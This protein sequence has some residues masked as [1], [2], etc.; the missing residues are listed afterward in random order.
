MTERSASGLPNVSGT[1]DNRPEMAA[2]LIVPAALLVVILLVF[3]LVL[4]FR[5]SL[6]IFSP[7]ELMIE[8]F[9]WQNY[10]SAVSD[11]YYL[12]TMA[13]TLRVSVLCTLFSLTVGFPAAYAL[14]RM[15]RPWKSWLT[16]LTI[17][18]LMVGGVV[19]SAG[20][21]MLLGNAGLVNAGLRWVNLTDAPLQMIYTPAAVILALVSVVLPYMILTLASVIEAIPRQLEEAALNMGARPFTV[22]RRV[23]FPLALPG[24]IAASALVFIL[25]MN[26]YATPVL[27]GGAKFK[28][29]APAVYDQFVRTTNWPF[30][31]ALALIMLMVTL[32]LTLV[33]S[34][35]LQRRYYTR[36]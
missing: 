24:V 34:A 27:V 20:W 33:G 28:M 16:L 2:L 8:A 32:T 21:L 4:L 29:M 26:A 3:P 14:A 22:F 9:T 36:N 25:C 31:A 18:P 35:L 15:P 13:T 17:F 5:Y 7:T 12:E 23:I 30:G 1:A 10:V 19:R 11:P 6:N